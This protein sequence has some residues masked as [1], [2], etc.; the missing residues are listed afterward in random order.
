MS[1]ERVDI[2]ENISVGTAQ[3]LLLMA[4]PCQIESREHALSMAAAIREACSGLPLNIVY[5][6]SFDKANRTSASAQRGIGMHEGLKILAEVREQYAMPVISDVHDTSQ[7]EAA[8]EHL[9]ILQ[10][11]AFLCRQTDLLLAAGK[12]GRTVHIKKG[13][14]LHPSDM[15]HVVEK[16]RSTGNERILVCERGACFGYRDLVVD[17]RSLVL[18]RATGCPVIFDATHSVQSMGGAGGSSGGSRE[19]IAPLSR[20]A[21]GVGVDGV[22]IECHENPDQAPSD[23]PSM[24]PIEQLRPLLEQLIAIRSSWHST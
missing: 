17:M 9:D 7:I 16:I 2:T 10:I 11:P 3:P 8:S 14:F 15:T 22:F 20:A 6:S 13:Q 23:G 1:S 21:M 18:M 24:L 4:G 5:K 19:F 12:S